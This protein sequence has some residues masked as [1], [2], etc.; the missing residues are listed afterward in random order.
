MRER[1]Q[2]RLLKVE[3]KDLRCQ[4]RASASLAKQEKE[5][6]DSKKVPSIAARRAAQ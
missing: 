4:A 6:E 2:E 1:A 5:Q 3:E